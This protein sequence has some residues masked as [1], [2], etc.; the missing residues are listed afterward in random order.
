MFI[1]GRRD[2][3]LAE[4]AKQLPDGITTIRSDTSNLKDID[5]LAATLKN[6]AGHIDVLYVNAGVAKFHPFES[7]TPDI[8]DEMFNVNFR[9]AYFTVQKLLPLM[10]EGASVVLTTSSI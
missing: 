6:K 3:T 4:A 2:K 7:V 9:G 5:E 1:T 8:F 10:G